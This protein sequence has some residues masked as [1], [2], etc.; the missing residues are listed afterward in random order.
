MTWTPCSS[1]I[2]LLLQQPLQAQRGSGWNP[3]PSYQLLQAAISPGKMWPHIFQCFMEPVWVSWGKN[4]FICPWFPIRQPFHC[5]PPSCIFFPSLICLQWVLCHFQRQRLPC[6]QGEKKQGS[7]G[8]QLSRQPSGC[9]A[10]SMLFTGVIG[11]PAN[12]SL[13]KKAASVPFTCSPAWG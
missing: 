3:T 12:S 2:L 10:K 5:N 13:Q 6:V 9:P 4:A 8:M 11:S 1:E 7:P